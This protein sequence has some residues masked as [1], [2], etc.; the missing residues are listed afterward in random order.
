MD[1]MKEYV[2]LGSGS[3]KRR[4]RMP[5]VAALGVVGTVAAGYLAVRA[6]GQRN[7][8]EA[9]AARLAD[10][11]RTLTDALELHRASKVDLDTQLTSCKEELV[12]EKTAIA[13]CESSIAELRGQEAD[14]KAMLAEFD[15]L[16]ARFKKMIDS[17]KLEVVFRRGEMIVKLPEQVLFPSGSATLSKDGEAALAEVAAVLRTMRGR[18]FTVAGHTDNVPIRSS[19]FASNWELSSARAVTVTQMLIRKG[20]RPGSLAAA[21]YGQYAPI[22]SNKTD[23]GRRRNRRIEIILEPDLGKLPLAK[24]KEPSKKTKKVASGSGR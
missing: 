16:T 24:L 5:A 3:G 19:E 9:T 23:T 6:A 11:N 13:T 1:A 10:E 4:W 8:A 21:G 20:V 22:A 12:S 14:A 7:D 2:D 15:R 17:G 18:R